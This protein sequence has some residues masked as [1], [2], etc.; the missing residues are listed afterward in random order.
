MKIT[1][2]G[3]LMNDENQYKSIEIIVGFLIVLI[4]LM[5]LFFGI[6]NFLSEKTNNY[7][8]YLAE[9]SSSDGIIIGSDVRLAGV[10]IGS[11]SNLNLNKETYL[12]TVEISVDKTI[13]IPEDTE[14]N[15]SSDGL[16]GEKYV[17]LN[18]GGSDVMLD[19]GEKLIYTQGSIDFLNLILKFANEIKK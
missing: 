2:V 1:K 16:L 14:A 19:N 6:F 13:K 4:T 9:F 8:K 18:V 11:V 5:L 7:N 15:I 10:K 17:S 12:A 3:P